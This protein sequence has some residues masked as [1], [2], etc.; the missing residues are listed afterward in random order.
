M[1][2]V[3]HRRPG[4]LVDRNQ[5]HPGHQPSDPLA[6]YL[7]AQTAKVPPH[8][9]GAIIRRFHEL[10]VDQ[11][12]QHQVERVFGRRL[13]IYPRSVEPQQGALPDNRQAGTLRVDHFPPLVTPKRTEASRK[14]SRSTKSWPIFA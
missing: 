6:A 2:R 7:M 11:P 4:F 13:I 3:G 10:F 12:H 1:F 8:L 5:P 9:P 14:K